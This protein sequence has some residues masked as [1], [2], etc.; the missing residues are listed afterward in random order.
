MKLYDADETQLM[1]D[2]AT[3]QQCTSDAQKK[4]CEDFISILSSLEND[5]NFYI[6]AC[7][8]A[9][10]ILNKKIAEYRSKNTEQ[11]AVTDWDAI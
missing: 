7:R 3:K 1:M 10:E 4:E 2:S 8:E 9:K 5:C 6:L 11:H